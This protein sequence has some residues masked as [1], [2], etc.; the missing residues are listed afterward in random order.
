[1]KGG[2]RMKKIIN[3]CAECKKELKMARGTVIEQALPSLVLNKEVVYSHGICFE[4]GV[5]LY[6]GD[7][8]AKVSA[9]I[10]NP[11]A[12]FRVSKTPRN[13]A[14]AREYLPERVNI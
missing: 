4:C 14:N 5:K 7:L 6:G 2:K 1:M 13:V 8:M 12:S 3:I 9:K 11:S 10:N